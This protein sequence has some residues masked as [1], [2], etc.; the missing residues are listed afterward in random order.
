MTWADLLILLVCIASGA[1]GFW[2]GF[3]KEALSLVT[4]L[5]AIW[6]AWR[7][8]WLVEP[9]L[10]EWLAAPELK[11]WAA[12]LIVF[13]VVLVIGGLVAWSVRALIRRTALSSTDRSL[14]GLFGLARGVL[15]VGLA[16][17]GMQLAGIDGD[18]WWQQ[19]KL[20]PLS[21]RV[22]DGIRHYAALGSR[23]L[24]EREIV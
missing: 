7:F 17:I 6:L 11:L 21:D 15:I 23:Y 16:V 18:P 1:F 9:M 8:S 20:R 2:R 3:A 14:G 4:W 5:A 22:A 10:G 12:R 19:S 13:V 24:T